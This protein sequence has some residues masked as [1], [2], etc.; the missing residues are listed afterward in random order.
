M[1]SAVSWVGAP[2]GIAAA[3]PY[4][5]A[6]PARRNGLPCSSNSMGRFLKHMGSSSCYESR[7]TLAARPTWRSAASR[8]PSSAPSAPLI[9]VSFSGNGAVWLRTASSPSA[10]AATL[11]FVSSN[12]HAIAMRYPASA[13]TTRATVINVRTSNMPASSSSALLQHG[14]DRIELPLGRSGGREHLPGHADGG[15]KRGDVRRVARDAAGG[16]QRLRGVALDRPCRPPR[17]VQEVDGQ[18]HQDDERDNQADPPD[19]VDGTGNR[20]R[21]HGRC[22]RDT[23]AINAPRLPSMAFNPS[24]VALRPSLSRTTWGASPSVC[25]SMARTPRRIFDR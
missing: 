14:G 18:R 13:R 1:R 21:A 10:M 7:N 25:R 23:D 22:C 3:G 6:T 5:L 11:F 19:H 4:G 9:V 16:L 17:A 8:P 12:A 2:R 20:G 15:V 24:R